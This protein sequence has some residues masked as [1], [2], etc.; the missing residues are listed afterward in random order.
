M[1]WHLGGPTKNLG[2]HTYNHSAL[3]GQKKKTFFPKW[4]GHR[5]GQPSIWGAMATPG[6]P[7]GSGPGHL[8][9]IF[10]CKVKN[11]TFFEKAKYEFLYVK[12]RTFSK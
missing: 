7:L 1:G 10:N 6:P 9:L 11:N 8:T 4:G 5:G 3:Y 2:G 12:N